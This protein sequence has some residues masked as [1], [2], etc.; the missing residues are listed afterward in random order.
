MNTGRPTATMDTGGISTVNG[1]ATADV[2]LGK[3]VTRYDGKL[4]VK[5]TVAPNS[6]KVNPHHRFIPACNFDVT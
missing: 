3:L 2:V 6:T 5:P 1:L 4:N